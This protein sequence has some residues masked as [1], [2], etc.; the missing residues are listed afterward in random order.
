VLSEEEKQVR[1]NEPM[2]FS[3]GSFF[4]SILKGIILVAFININNI[5]Q[6]VFNIKFV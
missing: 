5:N 2:E 3:I 1:K 6:S 4:S